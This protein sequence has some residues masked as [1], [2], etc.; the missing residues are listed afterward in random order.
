MH[1]Y[2]SRMSN[3]ALHRTPSRVHSAPPMTHTRIQYMHHTTQKVLLSSCFSVARSSLWRR[4]L[5]PRWRRAS[6]PRRRERHTRRETR[7]TEARRWRSWHAWWSTKRHWG[8]WWHHPHAATR[9]HAS[10]W[11]WHHR[12][13]FVLINNRWGPLHAQTDNHLSTK[14]NKTQRP[15]DFLL[16]SLAGIFRLLF[17]PY[18]SELLAFSQYKIHMLVEREH[19][20]YKLSPIIQSHF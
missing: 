8:S 2:P 6:K 1:T 10:P 5:E 20:S 13:L 9:W 17:R 14:N 18:V 4:R 7:R 12:V 19:L 16:R 15:L 11:S 3:L